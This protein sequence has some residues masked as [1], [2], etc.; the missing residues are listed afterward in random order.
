MPLSIY[1]NICDNRVMRYNIL[2]KSVL[3]FYYAVG[4]YVRLCI[5]PV[6]DETIKEFKEKGVNIY[7]I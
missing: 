5:I 4:D 1:K 3:V 2:C 7:E 6:N